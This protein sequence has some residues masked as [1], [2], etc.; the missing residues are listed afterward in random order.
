MKQLTTDRENDGRYADF[1][2]AGLGALIKGGWPYP[3]IKKEFSHAGKSD[4]DVAEYTKSWPS[5]SAPEDAEPFI[6]EQ[7]QKNNASYIKM[8]HEVGD[9]VGMDLPQ[10]NPELQKAVVDAAHQLGVVAVGHAFSY[11]G[12]MAL[13]RAGAD[14][15]THIFYNEPPNND[16]ITLMKETGAHCNPTLGLVAA[17]TDEG[18]ELYEWYAEDTN[19]QRLLAGKTTYKAHGLAAAQKPKASIEH[20]RANT[21]ALYQAGVPIVAGTDASGTGAGLPYG[22]GL[23]ME[24]YALI[25]HAGLSAVDALKAAT[26]IPADR[27][28]FHDRGRIAK[29][30][31][32]DLALIRT[33]VVEFLEDRQNRLLPLAAVFRNG[34]VAEPCERTWNWSSKSSQPFN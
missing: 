4:S 11:E 22:L 26:S 7:V 6:K 27:F 1:K 16:Y 12:A 31:K 2:C 15:L 17:Q 24:L 20:A 32:A 3:I 9:T 13:L 29:G 19:A 21:R 5:L 8:F 18:R 23:H 34:T 10:P 28:K 14:G 25:H 33:D 30:H